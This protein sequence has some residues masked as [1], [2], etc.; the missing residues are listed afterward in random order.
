MSCCETEI[1]DL[2]DAVVKL[3]DDLPGP[4]ALTPLSDNELDTAI[5]TGTP[6]TSSEFARCD[7]NHP[8]RRQANP[9]TPTLTFS[10]NATFPQTILLDFNSTEEWVSYEWRVRVDFA[11]GNGWRTIVVPNIPGF[12]RPIIE[13]DSYRNVGN[14]EPDAATLGARPEQ[15]Y[16]GDE[17]AH[18]SSTQRLYF[19]LRVEE[20]GRIYVRVRAKFIRN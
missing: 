17:V 12:Q 4:C 8:I 10:G 11:T 18:W 20:A 7:H 2:Q 1:K 5:R 14:P 6:G 13:S 19:G 15:P 9:G 3:I 16:M